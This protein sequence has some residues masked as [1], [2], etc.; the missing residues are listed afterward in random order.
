MAHPLKK[1]PRESW[2]GCP[3]SDAIEHYS[4]SYELQSLMLKSAENEEHLKR[5]AEVSS[6]C[7]FL[8]TGV[9]MFAQTTSLLSVD[10][11]MFATCG[12]TLGEYVYL[13]SGVVGASF[14]DTKASQPSKKSV[15]L[16]PRMCRPR[17][18]AQ[19]KPEQPD[20]SYDRTPKMKPS[21]IS[22]VSGLMIKKASHQTMS[23]HD[24]STSKILT[25]HTVEQQRQQQQRHTLPLCQPS[26]R[27][28]DGISFS[29]IVTRC[30]ALD[31]QKNDSKSKKWQHHVES[32]IARNCDKAA[33]AKN[34][35]RPW[36]TP[37]ERKKKQLAIAARNKKKSSSSA[38]ISL[39]DACDPAGGADRD[40]K[41]LI[42]SLNNLGVS[43]ST[44]KPGPF[45]ALRDGN[46]MIAP[47]GYLLRPALSIKDGGKYVMWHRS[48]FQAVIRTE[49][50]ITVIDG[51]HEVNYNNLAQFEQQFQSRLL[52]E[53][54]TIDDSS[55]KSAQ[56]AGGGT[57]SNRFPKRDFA[58]M[59]G[60][61]SVL[62]EDEV[63]IPLT[64]T[65]LQR[66]RINRNRAIALCRKA[67]SRNIKGLIIPTTSSVP[68]I[69]F[70]KN[71]HQHPNDILIT[72]EA[73]SHTYYLNGCQTD[74]SVTGLIH[75]FAQV[76]DAPSVIRK[77]QAGRNWPRSGYIK[78]VIPLDVIMK[79]LDT[80]G[81]DPLVN[82]LTQVPRNEDLICRL[83]AEACVLFPRLAPVLQ[84][85]A[86]PADE[87]MEMWQYN[88]DMAA[89]LGTHVHAKLELW[90]NGVNINSG[91]VEMKILSVFISTLH[92]LCAF[93]T[94][95]VIHAHEENL[96][97]SIDFVAIDS[98]GKLHLYDWKR[99]K[100]LRCKYTN[101][102]QSMRHPLQHFPDAQGIH[103]R[104]QLNIY[105][106][107]LEKYYGVEVASMSVVCLHPDNG[108]EP[109]IDVVP[110]MQAEVASIMAIQLDRVDPLGGGSKRSCY[111]MPDDDQPSQEQEEQSRGTSSS[112]AVNVSAANTPRRS[113][114][115]LARQ[116]SNF[117]T[118]FCSAQQT[119]VEV[120]ASCLGD[121]NDEGADR[122][123]RPTCPVPD[124]MDSSPT[125]RRRVRS[126]VDF[127]NDW[128]NFCDANVPDKNTI[129][130]DIVKE[131][132]GILSELGRWRE[133]VAAQCQGQ[134]WNDAL[135]HI[136]VGAMAVHK[137][138]L[139]DLSMREEVLFLE[140]IEGDGV[141]IRCHNGTCYQYSSAGHWE[142][143]RGVVHQGC[144][145]R[146]KK[147][148]LRLEG[149]FRTM[150][151]S[152]VRKPDAI[153]AAMNKMLADCGNDAEELLL[154]T[155]T[156]A[157]DKGGSYKKGKGKGWGQMKGL[158]DHDADGAD[159]E[160]QEDA[161]RFS[162][163]FAMAQTIS[164]LFVKL[165]H[166]LLGESIIK[167]F[168][169][170]CHTPDP[171]APGFCAKDMCAV[172]TDD[173]ESARMRVV[174]KKPDNNVYVSI[175]HNLL[176][177]V[178][179]SA[180]Q[181]LD[182]F[183]KQTFWKNGPALEC[184][185]AALC[186]ALR[187]LNVDRAF[188]GLGRG[189]VGQSLFTALL[190]ALLGHNH[191]CLDMNIYF[192]DDEMRKQAAYIVGKLVVTGQEAV[193]GSSR[194]LREDLYKKH[195]SADKIPER[196]PYA[197]VTTL[198][199]LNGWKRFELNTPV[200]F[201]GVNEDNY[202]SLFRRTL[203]IV[204]KARFLDHD[205][206]KKFMPDHEAEGVFVRDPTLKK[207]LQSDPAV[208]AMF[209]RLWGFCNIYTADQCQQAIEDYAINGSDEGATDKVLRSACGLK[210]KL[211]TQS[212]ETA[213]TELNLPAYDPIAADK[214]GVEKYSDVLF[215]LLLDQP[216]DY[217]TAASLSRVK[218][219][220]LPSKSGD[221]E[222][223]LNRPCHFQ[224]WKK[225]E[226]RISGSG[227][228]TIYIPIVKANKSFGEVCD[229]TADASNDTEIE[230]YD[231]L[232]LEDYLYKHSARASNVKVLISYFE[233]LMT[234]FAKKGKPSKSDQEEKDK[235]MNSKQKLELHEEAAEKLLE[236]IKN[237][238]P[239]ASKLSATQAS[240]DLLEAN[241]TIARRKYIHK[242]DTRTRRYLQGPG[243]QTLSKTLLKIVC[244][245]G[246]DFDFNCSLFRC[247][248]QLFDK[249]E[250]ELFDLDAYRQVA[251]DRDKVCTNILDLDIVTGKELLNAVAH[252][253]LY[254]DKLPSK[255]NEF[256]TKI[257]NESKM[258][259]W[260]ACST[261]PDLYETFRADASRQWPEATTF[262]YWW[263]PVEDYC[264]GA[265]LKLVKSRCIGHISCHFDG[266]LIDK[267]YVAKERA[268]LP[269]GD[270]LE[271]QWSD[272]IQQITG[273]R[274]AII[275]KQHDFFFINVLKDA[276]QTCETSNRSKKLCAP[277]NCIPAALG[278]I[279]QCE[280]AVIKELDKKTATN[281]SASVRQ[282]RSYK[283]WARYKDHVLSPSY[284]LPSFEDGNYL[285]HADCGG[286]P[287]CVGMSIAAGNCVIRDTDAIYN[288]SCDRFRDCY[289]KALDRST[290][291]S[292]RVLQADV[293][294]HSDV[295][296]S[297]LLD[298]MA[299]GAKRC[300]TNKLPQTC[301]G[302]SKL[303]KTMAKKTNADKFDEEPF[304]DVL[305]QISE[306]TAAEVQSFIAQYTGKKGGRRDKHMAKLSRAKVKCPGCPFRI[307][308]RRVQL[309]QHI[310][311][312]HVAENRYVASGTKQL[313]V[314][315]SLF[316]ED[317]LHGKKPH[318]SYLQRSATLL[319]GAIKPK[320]S[321]NHNIIDTSIRLLIEPTGPRLVNRSLLGK[322]LLARRVGNFYYNHEFAEEFFK[323]M[324]LSK[325]SFRDIAAK[326][327]LQSQSS[328]NLLTS[329]LPSQT[330]FWSNVAEDI[331]SCKETCDLLKLLLH[332]C[333]QANE[334]RY[335]SIDATVKCCLSLIGQG[336][337]RD[338]K[339]TR[340]KAPLADEDPIFK[341]L[342]VRGKSGAVLLVTGIQSEASSSIANACKEGITASARN[343]TV[344]VASDS[345]SDALF[346]ALKDV[347]PNLKSMGL[348]ACHICM[349][350][351]Q[352]HWHKKTSGSQL[353]RLLMN[354]FS[355]HD[356]S[357]DADD[358]GPFF[359]GTN[360]Q[361]ETKEE[362]HCMDKLKAG[363]ISK[364]LAKRLIDKIDP[365]TPWMTRI[366]FMEAIAALLSLYADEVNQK[367]PSGKSLRHVLVNIAMPVKIEWLLN[368]TRF[369]HTCNR[370]DLALLPSGTTANESLHAEAN[371][372]FHETQNLYKPQLELKLQ[373]FRL[374][375]LVSH[376][377]AMFRPLHR[378]TV[379]KDVLHR[380]LGTM[381]IWSDVQWTR[382]CNTL[383]SETGVVKKSLL[384]LAL[385]RKRFAQLVKNH[386]KTQ[387]KTLK[388]PASSSSVSQQVVRRTAFTIRRR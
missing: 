231:S 23:C 292:F 135:R 161:E 113:L 247:A 58:Q 297:L 355:R 87:I 94:E 350:Y 205:Y 224:L 314:I 223:L 361:M 95:W 368:D 349:L 60:H 218:S 211:Q 265:L 45:R 241:T 176:D 276:A 284:G 36:E 281:T 338:S 207:F 107:I 8:L 39:K 386:K 132:G 230:I 229:T 335:L 153:L 342:T 289:L 194:Q 147:Y 290:I 341:C 208:L 154:L 97:G 42:R 192:S 226:A 372:W 257:K 50:S 377:S 85:I 181:R 15:R 326:F 324:L 34:T 240:Q 373:M 277:G 269:K 157:I 131:E 12:L 28:D 152:T 282:A 380:T 5:W 156:K 172:F 270:S 158:P 334:Y 264:L 27:I 168:V 30:S 96:A 180:K 353:L 294:D 178:L 217:F 320:L 238:K 110:D 336:T 196:L 59:A 63:Q 329:M 14:H 227:V 228:T 319:Q 179:D 76:F 184:C 102:F 234:K 171:R 109:F 197:I 80:D 148:L 366:D 118:G 237:Q 388:R 21:R 233:R 273:Y 385:I 305:S 304:A 163:P 169:E 215:K 345:P 114:R 25:K 214:Q 302:S 16:R 79:L 61:G 187:G 17:S 206:L 246:N 142:S 280:A 173:E 303:P 165:Q 160:A 285:I 155:E 104:L 365:E 344:H 86:M 357:K 286:S 191:G 84:G 327:S 271:S 333:E 144:L 293:D 170:W 201:S 200:R 296:E 209:T 248:V 379:Q 242:L 287:H 20:C 54:V 48:H 375:K 126:D 183:L 99:S 149:V 33:E 253:K 31:M 145:A 66:H 275:Q 382:W 309:L 38:R 313:R 44:L 117:D 100:S 311:N 219:V 262:H 204:Y 91:S 225:S 4:P 159:F 213:P 315:I 291:V 272:H 339:A 150:P 9:Q 260:L 47:L 356:S 348:D 2:V 175:P 299:G 364:T 174:S 139:I 24:L 108:V 130:K 164:K 323:T 190:E 359:D 298:L 252:G 93:R 308:N 123:G 362:L 261:R 358:W 138:R 19:A 7:V 256:L 216:Q 367:T 57:C 301:K 352:A 316:D 360:L 78:A 374:A 202:W 351:E 56:L 310:K 68:D 343:Q 263:T 140:L 185:F 195:I 295:A 40:Q 182:R 322:K 245:F 188:W 235:L 370:K 307:F 46:A 318:A 6:V 363:D 69:N 115:L 77:M 82:A 141:Y 199:E 254:P 116:S 62:A 376:N 325:A 162:W 92:G 137:M 49:S 300:T 369:R 70:L 26:C 22:R 321:P 112:A 53:L 189:G 243:A 288:V 32:K 106:W 203:V 251:A 383:K 371:T 239:G 381:R 11:Y 210:P 312:H 220:H 278:S 166:A 255:A 35:R 337:Y 274:V 13:Q 143:F 89:A 136:A 283:D 1:P 128:L 331:M 332:E 125:K 52:Y 346:A 71:L 121:E 198:V 74:G 258:L 186:L 330:M 37:P 232:G 249:L 103:Y 98:T 340:A 306:L 378:Q 41:C 317:Q 279:L 267:T 151:E 236:F 119:D 122:T 129:P 65:D 73:A 387:K 177:P 221:R 146:V 72:F 259:R 222:S 105:R 29:G 51:D 67:L 134:G 43:I 384:P 64:L 88:A 266:L 3:I 127:L 10:D 354:K 133:M 120:H 328:S 75:R 18:Q 193:Q 90:L 81:T 212:P 244:P 55:G 167:Y 83:V 101:K 124:L 111:R 347:C 268:H 250:V